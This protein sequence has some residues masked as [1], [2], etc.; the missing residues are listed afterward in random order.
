MF[1]A[2]IVPTNVKA[3]VPASVVVVKQFTVKGEVA[4]TPVVRPHGFV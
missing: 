4:I 1:P 2:I 3:T